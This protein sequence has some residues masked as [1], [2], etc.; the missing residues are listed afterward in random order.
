MICRHMAES[1]RAVVKDSLRWDSKS[2]T[3][4]KTQSHLDTEFHGCLLL[5]K[6]AFLGAF[7]KLQQREGDGRRENGDGATDE[8]EEKREVRRDTPRDADGV[9][10]R[11]E[12]G[13]WMDANMGRRV[14]VQVEI[15]AKVVVDNENLFIVAASSPL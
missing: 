9:G 11:D 4:S 5:Q 13:M 7:V 8:T 12:I 1:S 6:G 14:R 15:G 10:C 3:F 2:K